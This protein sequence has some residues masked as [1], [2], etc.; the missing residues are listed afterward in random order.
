MPEAPTPLCAPT[1][2]SLVAQSVAR[3]DVGFP[4]MN[5]E[6]GVR[7]R[8]GSGS[9]LAMFGDDNLRRR[10]GERGEGAQGPLINVCLFPFINGCLFWSRISE[11]SFSTGSRE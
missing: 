6:A 2:S 5:D 8:P 7:A 11:L 10:A 1:A 3:G 4:G 9:G